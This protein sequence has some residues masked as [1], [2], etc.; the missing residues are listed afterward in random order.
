MTVT[1]TRPEGASPSSGSPQP[2]RY[3]LAMLVV[4]TVV[5]MLLGLAVGVVAL[6]PSPP[7]DTSPEAGFARDMSLHHGQ[8]VEMGMIAAAQATLPEVRALAEDIALTQQGQIGMMQQWLREW[9]LLPTGSEPIMAWMGEQHAVTEG[10]MPGMASQAEMAALRAAEGLEADR[11]FVELMII[12]HVGGIHMVDAILAV[13]DH[14]EVVFLAEAMKLGQE[15]EL[16]VLRDLQDRI[17]AQ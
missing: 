11:L 3:G 7:G 2:P 17:A 14:P 4:A 13:S 8:A 6:R 5:G 9:G 10:R 15:K 1:L 12:H 16:T